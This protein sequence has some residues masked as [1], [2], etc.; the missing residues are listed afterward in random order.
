MTDYL[1]EAG[2]AD[3]AA[4]WQTV[5]DEWEAAASAMTWEDASYSV[6]AVAEAIQAVFANLAATDADPAVLLSPADAAN[7][8][9]FSDVVLR[10]ALLPDSGPTILEVDGD[11]DWN[12]RPD[13]VRMNATRGNCFCPLT[14]P[15]WRTIIRKDGG[16]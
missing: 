16:D 2:R 3:L 4:T 13:R 1:T 9:S 6:D 7:L 10:W 11:G 5:V 12:T 15:R 8:D 14:A